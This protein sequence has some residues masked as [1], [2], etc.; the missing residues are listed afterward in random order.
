M[1]Q[2]K[3]T[4]ALWFA[5]V[6]TV[7]AACVEAPED[8]DERDVGTEAQAKG[9]CPLWG[10]GENSPVINTWDF[11]ELNEHGLP[12]TAG[13][14]LLGLWKGGVEYQPRVTGAA[15]QGFPKSG[16]GPVL[17][18]AALAGSYF[19]VQ[20]PDG[21][22]Y[23]I[24]IS[25]VSNTVGFW[26]GPAT[27][28]ETYELLYTKPGWSTS[29]RPLCK[30]PPA[31]LDGEGH[32][33]TNTYEAFL[34]T[35]DRYS[36]RNFTVTTG[37]RETDGWFN[38][39]CAGSALAKL[40]LNRHTSA[41]ST[42]AYQSTWQQRQAMLKMYVADVCGAGFAST[43]QGEPLRWENQ[44]GWDTLPGV[45][46]SYEAI[47]GPAG[48]ICLDTHRLEGTQFW[49]DFDLEN[50]IKASCPGNQLPPPCNLV[51]GAAIAWPPGSY[52]VTANP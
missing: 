29:A 24:Q 10:C 34:F 21:E 22:H 25:K 43:K 30:N 7:L 42:P 2:G 1:S 39:G 41:G 33:W 13:V 15:L 9:G 40:H 46:A 6:P 36:T 27:A 28:S 20:T 5:V 45:V 44:P 47:W 16:A 12:N 19:D 14:Q 26:V 48:A 31:R 3:L 49:I 18:G 38:I 52:L 8:G 23:Q 11:H 50:Q 4:A 51:P 37:A 17:Q 32:L 35:G